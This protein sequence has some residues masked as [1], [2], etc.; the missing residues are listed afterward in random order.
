[1]GGNPQPSPTVDDLRPFRIVIWRVSDNVFINNTLSAP[2]QSAV[3]QYVQGGGSFLM[4][5][6]EQLTRLSAAIYQQ[7]PASGEHRCG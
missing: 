4:S 5:S 3:Q 1:M 6:M 2:E 7:C